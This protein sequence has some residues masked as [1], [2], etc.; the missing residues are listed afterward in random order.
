M[1]EG[2]IMSTKKE[3][4]KKKSKGGAR[5]KYQEWLTEEGLLK[6]EGWARDGLTDEQIAE[7]IGIG[8]T[9]LYRWKNDYREIWEA[10]KRGKDVVDRQVENALLRR[11]LGYSYEEQEYATFPLDEDEYYGALEDHIQNFKFMNPEATDIDIQIERQNFPKYKKVL[12]KS[13]TKEVIPDTTAQIFWLKNRKPDDWR[14]K[15]VV[16]HDGEVK[17]SNPFAG[18]TEEELRRLANDST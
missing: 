18:L 13:K 2:E 11:A 14:D 6:L 17:V 9:T 12:I 16:Q 5:G 7:N 1:K 15:Q 8:T 10:L 3:S 4:K